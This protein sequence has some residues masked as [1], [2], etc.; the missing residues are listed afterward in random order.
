VP[1]T[2]P[3]TPL[4]IKEDDEEVIGLGRS[5]YSHAQMEE[6]LRSRPLREPGQH[7]WL[8]KLKSHFKDEDLEENGV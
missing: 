7:T 6:L 2:L 3:L 1:N 8:S 5:I 4:E